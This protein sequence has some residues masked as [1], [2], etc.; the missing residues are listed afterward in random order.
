[1]SW[2][3]RLDQKQPLRWFDLKG[4]RWGRPVPQVHCGFWAK[5]MP[6]EI[7]RKK[8]TPKTIRAGVCEFLVLGP[9]SPKRISC[10]F[11]SVVP[12][13]FFKCILS[14]DLRVIRP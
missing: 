10:E 3:Q 14:N 5:S 9:K 6:K 7:H 2:S 13:D 11:F 1:M 12:V 8:F 4:L